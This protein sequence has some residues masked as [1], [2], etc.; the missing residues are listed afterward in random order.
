[1]IYPGLLLLRVAFIGCSEV[2]SPLA[3]GALSS[4]TSKSSV[5]AP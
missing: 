3:V 5:L 1:M 4:Q 2:A